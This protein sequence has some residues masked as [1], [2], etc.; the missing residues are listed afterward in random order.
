MGSGVIHLSHTDISKT[1]LTDSVIYAL[2]W[3]IQF[4]ALLIN[5]DCEYLLIN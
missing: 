2:L 3:W 1:I 5:K 4:E